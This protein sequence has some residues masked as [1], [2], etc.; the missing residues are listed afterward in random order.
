[1]APTTVAD[2]VVRALAAGC[3]LALCL[4]PLGVFVVWR[5]MAY[6][7]DTLAHSAL[8]G[9]ALGFLLGVD[10]MVGVVAVCI[11]IALA[12]LALR[13]NR[14]LAEDTLL[15][16]LAHGTLALGLVAIAFLGSV[17]VDLMSY[18]FGDILAVGP[19]ELGW[20]WLGAVALVA[21]LVRL[22]RPFLALT[23]HEELARVEGVNAP[24][25][26]AAFMLLM[27]LAVALAMK[28]V[29]I[30][31]VT[32]LLILPAAAARHVTR[33]PEGMAVGAAFAGCLAV[34]T[35]LGG[36]LAWNL[37]AGPA[38]VVAAAALFALAAA[39]SAARAWA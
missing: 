19:D 38:V 21:A 28:L 27:A 36:A 9:V 24:R 26:Q 20:I 6:F 5:R 8:L 31:L 34:A 15:G 29:G 7:G 14:A 4:G 35:G 33:S 30:L 3:G 1:M 25:A 23:V 17:R 18:L 12:L 13:R 10:P 2:F 32:A 16:L 22:W 11:T 39:L 37:P